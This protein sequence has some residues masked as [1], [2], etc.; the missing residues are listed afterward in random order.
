MKK[1]NKILGKLLGLL[2][3]LAIPVLVY[4]LFTVLSGG[5]MLNTRAV[6]TVL[7]QAIQPALICYA[8][9][10]GLRIGM[11]NFAAGAILFSSAI[12][13]CG[14]SNLLGWGVAGLVL[15]CVLTSLVL[16][17][18][19]GLLYNWLRVP[20]M[21]LSLGVMLFYEALPR[22]FFPGGAVI[23]IDNA[24]L[25]RQPYCFIV[26]G[27][28]MLL[29]YILYNKTPY[30]HNIRAIGSNQAVALSA[31][32]NL[33]KIKFTN[34]VVG[35]VFL[36]VA[37]ALYMSGQGKL[38]NVSALGSMAVMMDGV[39]GVFLGMLLSRWSDPSFAVYCGVVTMKILSSGFVAVGLNA[40]WKD[41][42]TGLFMLVIM[43]VSA[44][45][46]MP[47]ILKANKA[48][49]EEANREREASSQA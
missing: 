47:A 5:R 9:L 14:I 41:V 28:M 3:T 32:L 35:G 33:D 12:I 13:G 48:Y 39:M 43:A 16:S 46:T 26:M 1:S 31:G 36:G 7:R 24:I 20:C 6:L 10:L 18:A 27:L 49:A 21:V 30:G 23:S 15:F 42:V 45:A 17:A 25:A 22:M 11:M 44:N 29:F 34:F 4:A 2:K 19:M 38:Q 40:T 37:S 8:L